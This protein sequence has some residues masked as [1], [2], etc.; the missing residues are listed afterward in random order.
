[1]IKSKSLKISF[2]KG[3]MNSSNQALGLAVVFL[4]LVGGMTATLKP[5]TFE[6]RVLQLE[7][8]AMIRGGA[9][10]LVSSNITPASKVEVMLTNVPYI[11]QNL[12]SK[13]SN[14]QEVARSKKYCGI[15]SALMVRAKNEKDSKTAPSNL[16][17]GWE[18]VN[19]PTVDTEMK[20]IDDKLKSGSY[21]YNYYGSNSIDLK[22]DVLTNKGLFYVNSRLSDMQQFTITT[23]ILR[24]VFLGTPG[25]LMTNSKN[26]DN[27]PFDKGHVN[28]VY[29]RADKPTDATTIIW[30]HINKKHQPVV[31]A[32]DSNKQLVNTV[33]NSVSP[34]VLHYLVI[35]GI[36]QESP[37]KDKYFYVHDPNAYIGDL[38]YTE[39]E[40]QKLMAMPSSAPAWVY[41][42]GERIT[43]TDPAYTLA[44][45]GD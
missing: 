43:W 6:G 37:A 36:S 10:C 3:T 13:Y 4:M 30:D 9:G 39:Q 45:E 33:V 17:D 32:V 16:W 21:G 34:P 31:V 18:N 22:V 40:L 44:V 5:K 23:E 14:P 19:Y 15:A 25:T 38:K 12:N 42:Y 29:I 35:R 7:E 2:L 24:S 11:T 27:I 8:A 1:M 26:L 41:K 28:D 20:K